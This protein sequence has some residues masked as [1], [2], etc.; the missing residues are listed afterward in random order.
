MR[1][2][3]FILV[4]GLLAIFANAQLVTLNL[5][6]PKTFIGTTADYN[7]TNSTVAYTLIRAEQHVK[8]TQDLYVQ[9]DSL[10][11]NHTNVSVA[12]W[13]KKFDDSAWVAIGSAVNWKG[14]TADTAIVISNATA[15]RYR[16]YKV[17]YTGS[18][19]GVTKVDKQELKLYLE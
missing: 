16:I 1:K 3:I 11:G 14:T 15:N 7:V 2:L 5:A 9:L 10:S 4:F 13:G 12:L 8:T 6:T 17:V 19:T 18:G